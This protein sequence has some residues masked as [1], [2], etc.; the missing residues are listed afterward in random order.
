MNNIYQFCSFDL[1]PYRPCAKCW[2]SFHPRTFGRN[3]GIR[4]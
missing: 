2:T 3:C 4:C 1:F